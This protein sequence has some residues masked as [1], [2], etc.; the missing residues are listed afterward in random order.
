[1][2]E[3]ICNENLLHRIQSNLKHFDIQTHDKEGYRHAAVA[4]TVVDI[5]N[6]PGVYGIP[7]HEAQAAHAALVLTRRAITLKNHAAQWA[8]PGG[9]IDKKDTSSLDAAYRELEEEVGIKPSDVEHLGS[10]GHFQTI[11]KK[12]IEAF[13]GVWNEKG[14]LRFD[15]A[16]ISRILRLPLRELVDIHHSNDF[17]GR[18]PDI[19]ELIYPVKGVTVWG[20]TARIFHY[21]I[22]L[23]H[24]A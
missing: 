9:H 24:P 6:D 13:V 8:L 16:E 22:E 21:L 19:G 15:T 2:N 18:I 5:Q 3:I 23:L 10:I 7:F 20:L 4:I 12:D 17:S 14:T 1:M 11:L